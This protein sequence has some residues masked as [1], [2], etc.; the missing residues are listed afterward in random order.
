MNDLLSQATAASLHEGL[1]YWIFWFLLSL[2][3][4]LLLFILLRDKDL[5]RRLSLALAG[6]NRRM[7]KKRLQL[8][9][10]REKRRKIILCR[11]IGRTVWGGKIAPERFGP[12]FDRL[13]RFE[14]EITARHAALQA[15]NDEISG[16]KTRVE[17]AKKKRRG[18]AASAA[19]D[20]ERTFKRRIRDLERKSKAERRRL[21]ESSR[22]K[23]REYERLGALAD[24]MRLEHEDL[25]EFYAR[26]DKVNRAVLSVIDK[27]EKLG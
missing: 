23:S 15:I 22:E 10:S 7:Q 16:A 20:E 11:G 21:R 2:I 25:P 19:N 5:R 17:D 27:I 3:V 14:A 9:L 4:L 26:I 1:P 6:A 13:G 12:S 8:R 24:E 18:P